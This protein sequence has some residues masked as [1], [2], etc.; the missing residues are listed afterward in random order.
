VLLS[1]ACASYD[2]FAHFE[3]RGDAFREMVAALRGPAQGGE[4]GERHH[5]VPEPVRSPDHDV[6][7]ARVEVE[8]ARIDGV[9]N[10]GRRPMFDTG[11]VLLEVYL[12]DF[13]GDLY[14]RTL[15]VAVI[16]WI[17]PEFKFDTVDELVHR[18]AEDCRIARNALKRAG[19]AFPPLGTVTA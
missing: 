14:G 18:M 2:Q 3:A 8:G 13:S 12:L 15:D 19:D 10:F 1:P 16:S 9:A 5:G 7:G 11:V 4:H 17:R 6:A